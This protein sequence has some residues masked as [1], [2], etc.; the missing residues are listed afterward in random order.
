MN[1]RRSTL[2][3]QAALAVLL[4]LS[5]LPAGSVMAKQGGPLTLV[6]KVG[7]GTAAVNGEEFRI[8]PPVLRN[9]S[10]L[11]PLGAFKQAFGSV[12]TLGE[13]NAV[14]VA[15]GAH[16]ATMA[17]G[18]GTA[19][20]DGRQVK[21]A[22]APRMVNGVLMAPLRFLADALGAKITA[23]SGGSLVISLPAEQGS[24][25]GEGDEFT[26]SE[27][28]KTRVG[29]SYYGWSLN[30]PSD[31]IVGDSG[32]EESV[33][34]FMSATGAY[35]LEIHAS[36]LPVP[37]NADE[38]LEQLVDESRDNGE[39]VL[40][41]EAVESAAAP[42]ARIVSRDANGALWE[43]RSYAANGRLYDLYLTDD[44]AVSYKDLAQYAG[45]LDSFRPEFGA[46]D[47][48]IRDL[49]TVKDGLREAGSKDY[50]ISLLVPAGWSPDPAGLTYTSAS[51][52][53][54]RFS[55]GSAASGESLDSWEEELRHRDADEF[56]TAAYAEQ[57][58]RQTKVS[59]VP[60]RV[61]EVRYNAGDGWMTV[62]QVFLLEEG[63]RYY[64]EYG[65][66]EE[67]QE[68]PDL[69]PDILGSLN[70]DFDVVQENFGR[71][72][73]TSYTILKNRT[74]T[75]ISRSYDFTLKLPRLWTAVHGNLETPSI[76]YAFTGG[77]FKIEVQS[78][79]SN[80]Y[81][82]NNLK[83]YYRQAEADAD[84]PAIEGETTR[85]IAGTTA[86]ELKI[87]QTTGGIPSHLRILVFSH[88]DKVYT[89][90]VTLGDANATEA[91]QAVIDQVLQSFAFTDGGER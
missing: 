3:L 26:D 20:V 10:V 51:G 84:G 56:L 44:N 12:V 77:K 88:R 68:A 13:N 40:D 66:P 37:L 74:L 86:A 48:S 22:A 61:R 49:S 64:A 71:L 21:L 79:G 32:D 63:Y 41:R 31:L 16:T 81:T 72:E 15:L 87:R 47:A 34:T 53:Y 43:S 62:Y 85:T 1:K 17:I 80:A 24:G 82:L 27:S 28:G 36:E 52:G 30:Y 18:S 38:L 33:A 67:Q 83:E 45:L 78:G 5:L 2:I 54:L 55:V 19:S 70:I 29:N 35:Y 8:A 73:Q 7:S 57:G 76:L 4:V 42:Y 65:V 91:Q 75:E 90:T 25:T 59:G 23:G 39:G 58:I 11:V 89:L 60:A 69:F 46:G 50:G 14:K 6:L 9:G